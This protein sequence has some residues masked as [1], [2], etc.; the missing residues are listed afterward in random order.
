MT[1]TRRWLRNI[2]DGEIYGWNEILAENPLTEEVT[3]EQA[4]PEKHMPKKQKGR[5][6]KVNVETAE[7]DIPDPKG[8]TPPELAEEA[9]KGLVRARDDKGHYVS[10]DPST[11]ENEAWVEKK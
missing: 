11:P 5:P 3:E 6:P 10:D 1:E 4:F 9:S 8:E 7:K 2:K